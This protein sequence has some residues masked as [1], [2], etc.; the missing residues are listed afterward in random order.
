[1]YAVIKTGGKQYRVATG[2]K[3]KVESLVG[4]VGQQLTLDRVLAI[5]NGAEMSIGTPFL[6]GATVLA[7]V[8]SHG[9]HDKVRIFKMQRRKHYQ[10]RQ[11]H[12]QHFTEIQISAVNA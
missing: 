5:G 6:A 9:R 4:D 10:K 12:R 8:V 3:I 11:G 7:T 2:E 1:M